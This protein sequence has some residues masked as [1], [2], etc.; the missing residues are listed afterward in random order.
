MDV[1]AYEEN[2]APARP[3][4][5]GKEKERE[6]LVEVQPPIE[7]RK[8]TTRRV[9]RALSISSEDEDDVE[10][11]Q[12]QD[13]DELAALEEPSS[14]EEEEAAEQSACEEEQEIVRPPTPSPPRPMRPPPTLSAGVS[15]VKK[16][17]AVAAETVSGAASKP[18]AR[19]VAELV[20]VSEE[21][22][23]WSDGVGSITVT[24]LF[25]LQAPHNLHHE[26]RRRKLHPPNL[27]RDVV[28]ASRSTML[29]PSSTRASEPSCLSLSSH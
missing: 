21:T 16:A 24:D 23:E 7:P 2:D 27:K 20:A 10:E 13:L 6:A 14:A 12:E 18:K 17:A 3:N 28:L 11:Q 22:G 29:Y 4:G 25:P 26:P 15:K 19:K 9:S 8:P 5:K 1:G